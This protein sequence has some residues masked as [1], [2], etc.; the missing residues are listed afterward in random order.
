MPAGWNSGTKCFI[1]SGRLETLQS[2]SSLIRFFL[3]S[4]TFVCTH[5]RFLYLPGSSSSAGDAHMVSAGAAR[6]FF[7]GVTS[8]FPVT[9]H[10]LSS[11]LF[12]AEN[13]VLLYNFLQIAKQMFLLASTH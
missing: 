8:L 6:Y 1:L 12:I 11:S 2:N 9:C 13:P 10:T 7:S 3:N 5:I 4:E